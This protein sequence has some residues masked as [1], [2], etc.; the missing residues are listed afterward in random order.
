MRLAALSPFLAVALLGSGCASVARYCN[1]SSADRLGVSDA[2]AFLD[3]RSGL[4]R[5][6][7]CTDQYSPA[8]F[9]RDYWN[10]YRRELA[11]RCTPQTAFAQGQASGRGED[12]SQKTRNG[13]AACAAVPADTQALD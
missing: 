1:P 7:A 10:G 8:Q 5:G 13:F 3:P 12:F 4:A 9:E 6:S 2:Q 11:F